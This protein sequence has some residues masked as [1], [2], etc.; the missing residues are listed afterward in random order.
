MPN[1]AAGPGNPVPNPAAGP[2]NPEPN[3]AAGPEN[4]EPN[5]AAGP[6]NAMRLSRLLLGVMGC[7]LVAAGILSLASL[8]FLG[9]R[10][11]AFVELQ[12]TLGQILGGG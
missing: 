12:Q 8:L 4:P 5:P 9:N 3:P 1:P 2:E 6:E 10:T 7:L 11:S